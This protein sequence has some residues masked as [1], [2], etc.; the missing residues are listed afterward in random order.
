MAKEEGPLHRLDRL[1]QELEQLKRDLLRQLV[2]GTTSQ[3]VTKPS[4]F[5]SVKGGD[6]ADEMIEDS[7]EN[8]FKHLKDL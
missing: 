8:L 1:E 4:L 7:K 3:Y 2:A 6:I 5:G